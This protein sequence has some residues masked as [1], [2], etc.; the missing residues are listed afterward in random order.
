M[1]YGLM[2]A[3]GHL[4]VTARPRRRKGVVR[5]RLGRW[6]GRRGLATGRDGV[7]CD[8]MGYGLMV[9]VGQGP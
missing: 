6:Q 3:V 2:V 9:A 5:W 8:G 1:G 4:E 7:G